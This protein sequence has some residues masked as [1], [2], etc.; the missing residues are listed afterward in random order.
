MTVSGSLPP[1]ERPA[2]VIPGGDEALDS[3]GVV[4]DRREAATAQPLAGDHREDH[5]DQCEPRPEVGVKCRRIRGWWASE[6]QTA[7]C[8][9][10]ASLSTTRC[11]WRAGGDDLLA[12]G[13]ELLAAV[14]LG[15]GLADPARDDL[16]RGNSVGVPRRTQSKL[17]VFRM[18]RT[19]RQGRAVRWSA[20]IHG[21]SS[22]QSI[23]RP[24]RRMQIQPD[25]LADL[26]SQLPIGGE[27]EGQRPPR[28]DIEAVP[29]P[30]DDVR[31]RSPLGR[32]CRG[33]HPATTGGWR[34]TGSAARSASAPA[35]DHT[36][37]PA[38][39][40][41]R[42]AAGGPPARAARTRRSVVAR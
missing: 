14:P 16:P 31:D 30:G 19:Y 32:R 2:G 6:A 4:G 34:R 3:G 13:R 26:A 17:A 38:A 33:Q 22:T 37:P 40:T 18:P 20:R 21:F 10:V 42:P 27:H 23:T 36:A 28:L 11:R 5:L 24:L 8:S 12:E 35:P 15:A 39:A 41:V 29:D 9:W 25:D 1:V 7:G